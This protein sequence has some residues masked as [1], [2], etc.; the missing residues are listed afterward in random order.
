MTQTYSEARQAILFKASREL[1]K[2][3]AEVL[4]DVQNDVELANVAT[5]KWAKAKART[6][7]T[8]ANELETLGHEA[9]IAPALA[10]TL[11]TKSK[12]AYSKSITAFEARIS[13]RLTLTY[14]EVRKLLA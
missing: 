9:C 6:I 14:D 13:E 11:L 3:A 1:R 5:L 7:C 4:D 8:Q 12:T 2:V 10:N